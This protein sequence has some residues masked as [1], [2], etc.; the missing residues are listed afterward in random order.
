MKYY[1]PAG[2]RNHGRPLKRLLDTWARNWS[3]SGPTPWQIYNNN[4]IYLLK[5]GFHPVAVVF[6][7]YTRTWSCTMMM[8]NKIKV[9]MIATERQI[10][11][12]HTHTPHTHTHTTHTHTHTHTLIVCIF[13]GKNSLGVY[14]ERQK[15]TPLRCILDL[16]LQNMCWI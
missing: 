9:D 7:T 5:L 8:M 15:K 16:V 2:R 11:H 13:H 4:N 14:G 6:N 1:S 12:T 10:T 3:T